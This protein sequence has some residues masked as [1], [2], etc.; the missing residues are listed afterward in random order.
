MPPKTTE[1]WRSVISGK[2]P[3]VPVPFCSVQDLPS[4]RTPGGGLYAHLNV[5]LPVIGHSHERVAMRPHGRGTPTADIHVPAGPGP[6]PVLIHLHG[7]A[8]FTGSAEGERKLAMR[9]AAAGFVVVCVDYALA[10]EEP[11]PHGLEDCIYAARWVKRHI[12]AYHGDPSRIAIGGGS[13][14]GNLAACTVLA[15]HASMEGLDGGDLAEVPVRFS[16]AV[17]QFA[18]LDLPAW[19]TDPG[20]WAGEPEIFI[21]GYLGPNFSARLR[22]PLASPVHH[23]QLSKMPPTYL[24]CGDQ[25]AL[26]PHSLRMANELA[27]AD[28]PVTVS[29]VA[30]ADHEFLK[31][32]DTVRGSGPE[33]ARICS[34][35]HERMAAA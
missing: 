7:G 22:H 9:Y 10:P 14:G 8:W 15:L 26:L 35:L 20:Y 19:L 21:G 25:D 29:V 33:H 11:F 31:V 28:V 30:G 6:F 34:W 24:C 2:P 12:A 13:A 23:P 18:V 3:G 5:D 27:K 17:L 1:H 16:A 4:R 32:P